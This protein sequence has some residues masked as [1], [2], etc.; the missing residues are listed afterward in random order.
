MI[1]SSHLIRNL[2]LLPVSVFRPIILIS[3]MPNLHNYSFLLLS[4]NKT[5]V[6]VL[7][8]NHIRNTL[9]M[10]LH[11]PPVPLQWI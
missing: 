10:E 6:I 11:W 9:S 2:R 1:A 8:P 7:D 5:E 3:Y 4:S